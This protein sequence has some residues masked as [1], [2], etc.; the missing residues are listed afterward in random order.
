MNDDYLD[1]DDLV[2]EAGYPDTEAGQD[3]TTSS[4]PIN[5]RSYE[6]VLNTLEIDMVDAYNRIA[7]CGDVEEAGLIIVSNIPKHTS[8]ATQFSIVRQLFHRQGHSRM[9]GTKYVPLSLMSGHD[10]DKAI[11]EGESDDHYNEEVF[12]RNKN[13]IERFIKYLAERDLSRDSKVS[14]AK[15]Q[16]LIPAFIIYLFST[17]TFGYII[18]CPT[19]PPEYQE[20]INR[21]LKGIEKTRYRL[22]DELAEEYE[23]AGRPAVADRVRSEGLGWFSREPMEIYGAARYRDLELTKDDIAIYRKY[24]GKFVNTTNA[25]TQEVISDYIY[26]IQDLRK[27]TY[28][29]LKDK[30]RAEAISDAKKELERFAKIS[31]TPEEQ[32]S[33]KNILF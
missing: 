26:V 4:A 30:T 23:K 3:T 15:K 8:K 27:G 14:R 19:M 21:A 28:Q 1:D 20:L 33:V 10:M 11:G 5:A 24:R 7:N 12:A 6:G 17:G 31:G 32:V 22:V 25:I 29:K 9:Q 2:G 18:D 13:L 16:R